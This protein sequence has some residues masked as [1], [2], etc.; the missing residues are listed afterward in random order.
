MVSSW[1][2]VL[3]VGLVAIL[4]LTIT[5]LWGELCR[6]RG[7]EELREEIK[8]GM[9]ELIEKLGMSKNEEMRAKNE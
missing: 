9:E 7:R 1:I 5:A 8:K 6:I 2:V 3:F 4:L